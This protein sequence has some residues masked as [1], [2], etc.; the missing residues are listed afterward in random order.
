VELVPRDHGWTGLRRFAALS[1]ILFAL[2]TIAMLTVL[3]TAGHDFRLVDGITT[4]WLFAGLPLSLALL[5][6]LSGAPR[7]LSVAGVGLLAAF[8]LFMILM[9]LPSLLAAPRL[10]LGGAARGT[11]ADISA[12]HAAWAE[13]SPAR[14]WT[15]HVGTGVYSTM[16]DGRRRTTSISAAP[17]VPAIPHDGP[18]DLFLCDDRDDLVDPGTGTLAGIL[19][20]ATDLAGDAVRQLADQGLRVGPDPRCLEPTLFGWLPTLALRLLY[21]ALF[22]AVVTFA[23]AWGLTRTALGR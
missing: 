18:I 3:A 8:F 7:R 12:S 4:A 22:A 21:T 15:E 23:A 1:A 19:A 17:I 9:A 20:P 6:R 2:S 10:V 11:V 16:K 14:V 5:A 13:V